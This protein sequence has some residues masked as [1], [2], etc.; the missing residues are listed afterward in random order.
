MGCAIWAYKDWVGDLYPPGSRASDFL[1]L[2]GQRFTAVEG[3]TTFYSVPDA[4]TVARWATETPSGFQFCLKLPRDVTHTG[5]LDSA[6]PKAIAFLDRMQPLGDRLGPFFAQLPPSCGPDR[7]NDLIAF[8]RSWPGDRA[9]LA[10]EVRHLDWFNPPHADRLNDAL[11]RLGMG[12]VLLDTR[13]IYD[14]PDDP[15]LASER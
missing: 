1:R 6:I 7:F 2:Y 14:C 10:L 4:K 8:L 15:Q 11:A 12:R 9:E 5:A 13:P 3:N